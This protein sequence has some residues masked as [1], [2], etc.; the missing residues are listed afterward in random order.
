MLVD[1]Y[2]LPLMEEQED[3]REEGYEDRLLKAYP[4]WGF[5]VKVLN[6]TAYIFPLNKNLKS[7]PHELG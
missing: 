5:G 4:E 2:N 6:L 7:A 1:I 3:G